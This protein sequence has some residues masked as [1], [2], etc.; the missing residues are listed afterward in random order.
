MSASTFR[1]RW[2]ARAP[3]WQGAS[4]RARRQQRAPLR[5]ARSKFASKRHK[6]CYFVTSIFCTRIHC[7]VLLQPARQSDLSRPIHPGIRSTVLQKNR[8]RDWI[9]FFFGTEMCHECQ[10]VHAS[11]LSLSSRADFCRCVC[12]LALLAGGQSDKVTN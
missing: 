12:D 4:R 7:N 1:D 6:N 8:G 10:Y 3:R 9:Y 11:L 5:R 2:G